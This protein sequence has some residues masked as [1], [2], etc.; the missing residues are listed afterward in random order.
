[1]TH[2][3]EEPMDLRQCQVSCRARWLIN[4]GNFLPQVTLFLTS[5]P[6]AATINSATVFTLEHK[7]QAARLAW[8]H[9]LG[10]LTSVLAAVDAGGLGAG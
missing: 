7:Q 10:T 9:G 3:V 6:S 1:M 5:F 2:G 4:V 8:A